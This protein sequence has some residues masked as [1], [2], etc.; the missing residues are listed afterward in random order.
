[1]DKIF[2]AIELIQNQIGSDL[3]TV[4]GAIIPTIIE[5]C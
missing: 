4:Y 2:E 3:G 5:A 1:M